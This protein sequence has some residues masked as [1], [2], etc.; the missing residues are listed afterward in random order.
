MRQQVL[1]RNVTRIFDYPAFH[2]GYQH[3]RRSSFE[4]A[5]EEDT[6]PPQLPASSLLQVIAVQD[7][8][9]QYPL[10]NGHRMS[11]FRQRAEALPGVLVGSL[12]GP[13]YVEILK[14]QGR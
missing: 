6:H 11:V 12:S 2:Q 5:L 4:D 13:L 8:R 3:G 14:E 7:E 10:D 1:W 9:G